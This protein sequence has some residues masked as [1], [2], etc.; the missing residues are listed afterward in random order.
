MYR[1]YKIRNK[2]LDELDQSPPEYLS[3]SRIALAN[4][5]FSDID[6]QK[7]LKEVYDHVALK[8]ALLERVI[9]ARKTHHTHFH[10]LNLDYGH[11]HYLDSLCN[12]KFIVLRA[13]ERLERRIAEVLY[14][15]RKWFRWVRECQD[16]EEAYRDSEKKKIKQEAA[17]FR[18]HQREIR[19]RTERLKAREDS[20]R[21]AAELDQAYYERLSQQAKE[22]VEEDWDPIED[23]V[24][25][26][27]GTYVDLIK[28]FLLMSPLT[29][30]ELS[31]DVAEPKDET[32]T[33]S[34]PTAVA[35]DQEASHKTVRRSR[36]AKKKPATTQAAKDIPDKSLHET[37]AEIRRR[38][39]EGVELAYA[40]GI[41]IAGTIDAPIQ[42]KDKT[43]PIPDED[44]DQLLEELAEIKLLLFCRLLLSH[45]TVLPSALRAASVAEF[46]DDKEISDT[47]L[48]DLCLKMDNPGL[49]NI[50][51]ACADFGRGAEEIEEKDSEPRQQDNDEKKKK[52][53]GFGFS[54]KVRG[55]I[56]EKW[57]SEREKR[58]KKQGQMPQDVLRKYFEFNLSHEHLEVYAFT[59]PIL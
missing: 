56:P 7:I 24:E 18:C 59:S 54:R 32:R 51:D 20:K 11:Q 26:E 16:T 2:R 55:G 44:I 53:S 15:Q 42:R 34:E 14:E 22:K 19:L 35:D 39:K 41:H 1:G 50:R 29:P 33:H 48:R 28:H 57:S 25:N 4:L 36:T 45:A 23:I 49:Q 13:L 30:G 40:G 31:G 17:L 9:H 8:H 27:R 38:L 52:A 10:S 46:L 5:T 47:D 58:I 12:R 37:K 6:S 21:Q 3:K 43:A